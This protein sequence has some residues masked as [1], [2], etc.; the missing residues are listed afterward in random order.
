MAADELGG[1][2]DNNIGT[3]LYGTNEIGGAECVVHDEDDAVA[4]GYCSHTVDVKYITVGVA[5]SF[6]V[7]DFCF[8][9]YCCLEGCQVI[10]VYD[11][12]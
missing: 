6:G 9:T 3:V 12:A 7:D 1:R 10:D 8:R 11:G 5:E 4:M 2:M